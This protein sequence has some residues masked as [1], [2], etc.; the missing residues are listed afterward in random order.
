MRLSG[1]PVRSLT[2]G[3]RLMGQVI[4]RVENGRVLMDFGGFKATA[5]VDF[6]VRPGQRFPVLVL[7]NNRQL[8]LQKQNVASFE[9]PQ[10]HAL[11]ARL[12]AAMPTPKAPWPL[13]NAQLASF[14]GDIQTVLQ[15]NATGQLVLPRPVAEALRQLQKHYEPL[16]LGPDALR[17]GTKM[18]QW[19]QHSG[20]FFEKRLARIF[21]RDHPALQ[22]HT[23][24]QRAVQQ[25]LQSD[26]KASLAQIE[27][28]VQ[29]QGSEGQPDR[30]AQPARLPFSAKFSAAEPRSLATVPA[31]PKAE[32]IDPA[33]RQIGHVVQR[34][35][36]Q[37]RFQQQQVIRSANAN[38]CADVHV[39]GQRRNQDA[40]P[41]EK[42]GTASLPGA[43]FTENMAQPPG[44]TAGPKPNPSL[45][46][47]WLRHLPP[48]LDYVPLQRRRPIE[49]VVER[50]METVAAARTNRS[51]PVHDI[52]EKITVD[53]QQLRRFAEQLYSS[54][55][56][57]E[58]MVADHLRQGLEQGIE[59]WG[60]EISARKDAEA[61]V[62]MFEMTL[63]LEEG[64]GETRLK[65]FSRRRGDK[66]QPGHHRITLLLD[67]TRLG[68]MRIDLSLA[69]QRLAVGIYVADEAICRR[70][71]SFLE[72]LTARL[73]D[74][75]SEVTAQIAV[76]DV[77]LRAFEQQMTQAP[78]TN[79]G[80]LSVRV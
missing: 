15:K 22:N 58:R 62:L 72:Q 4:G 41:H 51:L 17:L 61:P 75:F 47:Q 66:R 19:V 34:L 5:T 30:A 73:Q 65:M 29:H 2:P 24:L 43:K 71:D 18:Q 11:Q 52:L 44:A 31:N 23:Q 56:P 10:G 77:H 48:L 36:D 50:L 20:L 68:E 76:T 57:A 26:A 60:A 74:G 7:D 49:G 9:N 16:S 28:F 63:P 53:L 25:I 55:S 42:I 32:G 80:A 27:R 45:L 64:A 40:K 21:H 13:T 59:Q 67:M 69:E 54:G 14:R 12:S 8:V 38:G 3:M 79:S 78:L 70:L 37:I 6:P 35:A 46:Q 1:Q 33:L 39:D